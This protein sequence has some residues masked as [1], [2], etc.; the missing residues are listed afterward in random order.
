VFLLLI[1]PTSSIVPINDVMQERRVYLPFLGF[2]LIAIE[3]LRRLKFTQIIGVGAAILAVCSVATYQRSEVLASSMSLWQDTVAK[4]PRKVRPRFQLAYAK[5]ELGRC[6]EAAADYE[7]AS[8]LAPPDYT[9][10]TDWALALDCAGHDDE[11]IQKLRQATKLENNAHAF[12][13]LGMIYGKQRKFDQALEALAQ[14]EDID[15]EF[16]IIYVY[17]GNVYEVTGDFTQ[18]GQQ[19]QHALDLE[20][21][22]ELARAGLTR[23]QSRR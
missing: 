22:N 14:A 7:T 3:F 12:S 16:A 4:S 6:P 20:P 11:A 10:L 18:A 2:A 9:L 23:L 17:R 8:K 5:F 21:A 19:Y 15:P 13:Q 1:S